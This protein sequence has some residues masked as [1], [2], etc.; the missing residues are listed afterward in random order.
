[1]F[2]KKHGRSISRQR[3]AQLRKGYT[4]KQSDKAYQI[5]SRLEEG[6]DWMYEKATVVYTQAGLKKILER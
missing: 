4:L 6:T 5:D 2:E 3:L 1:M